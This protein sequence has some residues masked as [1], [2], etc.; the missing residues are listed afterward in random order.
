MKL[1]DGWV[2]VWSLAFERS[3]IVGVQWSDSEK[4]VRLHMRNGHALCLDDCAFRHFQSAVRAIA[5][6]DRKMAAATAT[7]QQR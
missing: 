7:E 2:E 6:Y 3:Q 5:T 1:P 4:T